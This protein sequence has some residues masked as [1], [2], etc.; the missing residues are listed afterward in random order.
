MGTGRKKYLA[1]CANGGVLVIK[2]HDGMLC[3]NK[4]IETFC[5]CAPWPFTPVC[6]CVC[7]VSGLGTLPRTTSQ[8]STLHY[9]RGAYSVP[10]HTDTY[11]ATLYRSTESN[12]SRH[13]VG[14]INNNVGA[15]RSP[16]IDS[17]HKDPR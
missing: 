16:S 13:A 5:R 11:R 6:V 4:Y 1:S 12:Y 7:P 8:C 17:I 9:Q 15:T 2:L 3:I 14:G 10:S